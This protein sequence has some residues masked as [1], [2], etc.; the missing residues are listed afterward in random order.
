LLD[1]RSPTSKGRV[2][3]GKEKGKGRGKEGRGM[4]DEGRV[5]ERSILSITWIRNCRQERYSGQSRWIA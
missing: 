1:L 4:G 2:G 5:K 3:D